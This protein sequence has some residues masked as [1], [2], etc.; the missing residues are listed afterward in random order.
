MWKELPVPEKMKWLTSEKAK[1][2]ARP[3]P[4]KEKVV[5]KKEKNSDKK[6]DSS[7]SVI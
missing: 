6:K 4:K 7:K 3:A 1:K 2:S 5:E